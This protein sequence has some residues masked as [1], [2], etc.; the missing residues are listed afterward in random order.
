MPDWLKVWWFCFFPLALPFALRIGWEK[1]VWTWSRGPQLVGFS[2][3]HMHPLFAIAGML[4]SL[5]VMIWLLAAI[6]YAIA[7]RRK[8]TTAD[9]AMISAA[10]LVAI[11][12]LIPDTFFA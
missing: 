5:G 8:A 4:F 9:F 7:R 10:L 1:T 3:M 6:A 12:I 2:L 11:A